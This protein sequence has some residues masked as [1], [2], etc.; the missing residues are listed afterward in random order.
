MI[1]RVLLETGNHIN[2]RYELTNNE[3]LTFS[4]M[5][6]KVSK[7]IGKTIKFVSP[8]L[9]QLFWTKRKENMSIMLI[10]VMLLP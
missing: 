6:E 8:N 4:E 1:A 9:F 5:T 3:T 10:L 2:K 7:G